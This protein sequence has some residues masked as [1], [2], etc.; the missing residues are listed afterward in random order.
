MMQFAHK[1]PTIVAVPEVVGV[2]IVA[3]EPQVIAVALHIEHV[4]I[5][6]RIRNV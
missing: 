1:H 6:I 5:A 3:V 4:E 2:A